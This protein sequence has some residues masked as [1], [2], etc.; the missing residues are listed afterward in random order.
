M[1]QRTAHEVAVDWALARGYNISVGDY[2][3]IELDLEHSEDRDEIIKAILATDMPNAYIYDYRHKYLFTFS[4]VAENS[5]GETIS[6]YTIPATPDEWLCSAFEAFE[7]AIHYSHW[8]PEPKK[9]QVAVTL[10]FDISESSDYLARMT[11]EN[12]HGLLCRYL[13]NLGLNVFDSN[14]SYEETPDNDN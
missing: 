2:N 8:E 9:Y 3:E 11:S 5:P 13:E 12:Y 4:V 7:K 10:S 6:D 14:V 1:E